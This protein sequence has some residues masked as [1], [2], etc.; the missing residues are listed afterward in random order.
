M[1]ITLSSEP[2]QL[3]ILTPSRKVVEVSCKDVSFPSSLGR[4]QI[5]PGHAELICQI[6]TGAVYFTHGNSVGLCAVS[7]GAAD[8]GNNKVTL[9]ADIAEEAARIDPVRAQKALE[10]AQNRLAGKKDSPD[11][12]RA[13]AAEQKALARLEA[14]NSGA[15]SGKKN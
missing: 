10:R 15:L 5:L 9:L 7:G 1:A 14:C 13:I 12:A 11:M 8:V 4:L 3:V 2:I 6:G